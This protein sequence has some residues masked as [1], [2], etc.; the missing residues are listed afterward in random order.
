MG[1]LD[2][3]TG[4]PNTSLPLD[5]SEAVPS[6]PVYDRLQVV[7]NYMTTMGKQMSGGQSNPKLSLFN[8]IMSEMMKEVT[9]F[10]APIVELYLKQFAG[11]VYWTSTGEV[12]E[13]VEFPPGFVES[14]PKAIDA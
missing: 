9:E 11:L 2:R 8:K 10:P 3:M 1:L 5:S 12:I 6:A 13:G 4:T 14:V 7:I